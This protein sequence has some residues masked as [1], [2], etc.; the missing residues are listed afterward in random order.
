MRHRGAVHLFTVQHRKGINLLHDVT[1]M[2]RGGGSHT[3]LHLIAESTQVICGNLVKLS[4][5]ESRQDVP[6]DDALSHGPMLLAIRAP[7]SHFP[8]IW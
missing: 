7:T 6:I 2:H 3:N 1:D 4:V 8:V 5:L